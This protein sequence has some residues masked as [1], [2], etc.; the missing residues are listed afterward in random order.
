MVLSFALDAQNQL[1]SKNVG[2]LKFIHELLICVLSAHL[3]TYGLLINQIP[4]LNTRQGVLL[5]LVARN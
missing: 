1:H 4:V 2:Q 5:N 3:W